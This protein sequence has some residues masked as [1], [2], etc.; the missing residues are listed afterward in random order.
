MEGYSGLEEKRRV[1]LA[2]SHHPLQQSQLLYSLRGEC[3]G[4]EGKKH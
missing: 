3:A 1:M 4:K 2:L